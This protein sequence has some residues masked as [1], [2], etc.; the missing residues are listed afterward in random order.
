[1]LCLLSTILLLTSCLDVSSSLAQTGAQ[2]SDSAKSV[3]INGGANTHTDNVRE[4]NSPY[5]DATP[6]IMPDEATMYF[7]S[8]RDGDKPAIFVAHRATSAT[9][10]TPEK[11]IELPG[12]ESISSI[13][14]TAD[15]SHAVV[16]CC[17]RSDGILGS[18]DLYEADVLDGKIQSLHPLGRPVNTEWWEG[19]PCLSQDGQMLFFASDRKHGHGGIDIYMSTKMPNGS[20]SEPIDLSFNTSGNE[21]SPMI[22]SDN[23]TL[24]FAADDL[25]GGMGGYDIYV[26]HR[27]GDNTWTTP[28]NLGPAVNTKSDE[29]FFAVPPAE[30]AIYL[31]SNRPGGSGRF[32]IFRISPNPLKPVARIIALKGTVLDAE[33]NLPIKSTPQVQISLSGA[34]DPVENT[35]QGTDYA[36]IVPLGKL[37]K[38][39]ADAEGYVPGSIEVQSP[40]ELNPTGFTQDIKLVP[41]HAR[42]DGHVTNV[43]THKPVQTRLTLDELADD[44]TTKKTFTL[45]TPAD[46]SFTFNVNPS[47]KYH[48]SAQVENYEPYASDVAIPVSHE[49]MERVAKEIY[50]TPSDILPVMVLFDFNKNDLKKDESLK[51]QH[52]IDQVKENPNVRIEVNGHTDDVGT[53]EYNVKLSERRAVSVE[54]YLLSRGVPRD[55]LA[56]VKGFGKAQPIDPGTTD[57]A[58]AK[59]R[60]VEVRIVGKH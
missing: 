49:A 28:K 10:S 58:R 42:I 50:L 60:R 21:L 12:K 23:Q 16:G 59:N 37:V 3:F 14:F 57:V 56:V 48:L 8:Y 52:F 35:G 54:D 11:Y 41:S 43:F 17:N 15:G 30:D 45:E 47:E 22:A 27:T 13:S 19:Q 5:D 38:I 51:L 25:P 53:D 44:G 18:C 20:W 39:K 2:P 36:A 33:T 31:A 29:M 6:V 40:N 7:T 34:S 55:Q 46:G 24:Y 26:T 32:D 1:V 9:W 4:L